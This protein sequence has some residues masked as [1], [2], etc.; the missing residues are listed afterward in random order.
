MN[1]SG[2]EIESLISYIDIGPIDISSDD[3]VES[4]HATSVSLYLVG[5][6][7]GLDEPL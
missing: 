2:Y 3:K 7:L 6:D 4:L 1:Y 5:M